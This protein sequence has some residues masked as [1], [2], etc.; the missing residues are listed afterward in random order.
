MILGGYTVTDNFVV[1]KSD[2]LLL[3][4]NNKIIDLKLWKLAKGHCEIEKKVIGTTSSVFAIY[5]HLAS[6]NI[7]AEASGTDSHNKFEKN[8]N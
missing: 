6:D 5:Q 7:C 8:K 2:L 3:A 1:S 4:A